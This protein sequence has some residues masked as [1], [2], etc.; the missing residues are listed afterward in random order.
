MHLARISILLLAA[1]ASRTVWDG[2]YTKEQAARGQM[3]YLEEC[4]RC[5][6]A[7]LAGNEAPALTGEEFLKEWNGKSAGDLFE[8]IRKSMPDDDPGVLSEHDYVDVMAFVFGA[9]HFPTG[10]KELEPE[11]AALKEIRI[12]P[13]R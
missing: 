8:V 10:D 6:G 13:R 7:E 1:A 11:I 5:H 2:V 9:N 3:V 12:E 4:A